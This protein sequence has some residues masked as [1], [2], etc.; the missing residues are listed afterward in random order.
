MV[1]GK[2]TAH[3]NEQTMAIPHITID[4]NGT[5]STVL[6]CLTCQ[7]D[8]GPTTTYNYDGTN[9]VTSR[10]L[11]N[12]ILTSYQ[13]DGLGRLTRLL[14]AKGVATL[15]EVMVT[16]WAKDSPFKAILA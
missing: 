2:V 9:K 16:S 5:K 6:T 11:S 8:H 1:A 13:Y 3:S 14:D 4:F 7:I 12:G 10:R 15:A